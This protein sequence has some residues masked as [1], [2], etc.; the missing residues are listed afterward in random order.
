MSSVG[1]NI[2]DAKF[3]GMGRSEMYRHQITPD[4]FPHEKR[5]LVELWPAEDRE[6]YCGG[7]YTRGVA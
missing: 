2:F 5:M 1:D 4:L 7:E 6:A 3:N